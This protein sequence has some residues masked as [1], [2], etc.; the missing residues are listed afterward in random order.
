MGR[1]SG[2]VPVNKDG[3]GCTHLYTSKNIGRCLTQYTCTHCE[4]CYQID[5]GD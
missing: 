4:D 5:S 2:R 3:V 1:A